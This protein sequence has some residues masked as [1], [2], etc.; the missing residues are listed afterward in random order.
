MQR[1][2]AGSGRIA[3]IAGHGSRGGLSVSTWSR[4]GDGPGPGASV[5]RYLLAGV[6]PVEV[7][8]TRNG[9][10]GGLTPLCP[11]TILFGGLVVPSD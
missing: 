4:F 10:V 7:R 3:K 2:R 6:G 5:Y 8:E 1:L 11:I 9:S